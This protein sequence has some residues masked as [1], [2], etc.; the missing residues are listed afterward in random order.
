MRILIKDPLEKLPLIGMPGLRVPIIG[1]IV[2]K[3][4]NPEFPDNK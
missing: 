3:R 1:L 4:L 2:D